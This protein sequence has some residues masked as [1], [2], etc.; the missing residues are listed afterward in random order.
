M[1]LPLVLVDPGQMTQV[2]NNIILNAVQSALPQTEP[3]VV[4]TVDEVSSAEADQYPGKP[5]LEAEHSLIRVVISDDGPGFAPGIL[6][7]VF[8]PYFSASPNGSGLGL[9]SS[10][11]IVRNRQGDI[12]AANSA[13]GGAKVTVLIPSIATNPAAPPMPALNASKQQYR[14]LLL[15]DE[16]LVRDSIAM[17]LK[18]LGHDV[19]ETR[20]GDETL[21]KMR[22]ETLN[23]SSRCQVALLDLTMRYGR[24]GAEVVE[25]LKQ[26]LPE[27]ICVAISG[28]SDCPVM[29]QPQKFGFHAVLTKPFSR[30]ELEELFAT[31]AACFPG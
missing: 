30:K 11:F 26:L 2:F 4:I 13:D 1:N 7:R 14:V 24:G 3:T 22:E 25:E 23:S 15:D 29:A 5:N 21:T 8:E 19:V 12:R 20:N 27:I 28:Y 16:D 9:T 18:S 6:G 10:F 31:V 17:L